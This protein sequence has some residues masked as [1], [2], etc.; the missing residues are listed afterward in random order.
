MCLDQQKRRFFWAFSFYLILSPSE[1][2][3]NIHF[4]KS[5]NKYHKLASYLLTNVSVLFWF[6]QLPVL[7]LM[8]QDRLWVQRKLKEMWNGIQTEQRIEK[9][10]DRLRRT[11]QMSLRRIIQKTCLLSSASKCTTH[12]KPLWKRTWWE[13]MH[14]DSCSGTG[15]FSAGGCV[16]AQCCLFAVFTVKALTSAI[17]LRC[18][19]AP[20]PS[21]LTPLRVTSEAANGDHWWKQAVYNGCKV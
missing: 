19:Q 2:H 8:K 1:M 14:C 18:W 12:H 11:E 13:Q 6:G 16:G 20:G 4:L 5:V 17:T 15:I 7:R 21:T 10:L 3:K 9:H